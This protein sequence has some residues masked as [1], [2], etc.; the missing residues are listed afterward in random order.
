VNERERE[1]GEKREHE[2]ERESL[3]G[4]ILNDRTSTM[5]MSKET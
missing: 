4:T 3:L 5:L 2:R 1:G